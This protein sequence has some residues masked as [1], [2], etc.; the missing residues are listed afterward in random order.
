MGNRL[1]YIIIVLILLFAGASCATRKRCAL[2]FPPHADTIK[3]VQVKDSIITRDTTIYV[4]LPGETITDSVMV[5]CTEIINY[6][7]D[8]ARA[9]TPLSKAWAW[10]EY[11]EIKLK[12]VQKDTT[13]IKEL[14]NALQMVSHWKSE[15]EKITEIPVPVK[16]I[17]KIYQYSMM[18]S[19]GILVFLV[20][21]IASQIIKITK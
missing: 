8:T 11:P 9:E 13:I 18:F 10:W 6:T 17:P 2:K 21:W 16:Y 3:V 4:V 5:P 20:L 14:K 19:I 12:L 7:A 1:N 15:Y